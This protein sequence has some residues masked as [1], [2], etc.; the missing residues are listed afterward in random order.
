MS[1]TLQDHLDVPMAVRQR[2]DALAADFERVRR[3]LSGS[4]VLPHVRKAARKTLRQ[5]GAD[6]RQ[7]AKEL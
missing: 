2:A 7:L 5:I 3:A 6:A 1:R 4:A